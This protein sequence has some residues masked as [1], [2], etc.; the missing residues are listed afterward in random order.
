MAGAPF[1][2]PTPSQLA[3]AFKW[4]EIRQVT[5]TATVRLFSNAYEVDAS[6]VGRKVELVFDPFDLEVMEVRFRGEPMGLAKPQDIGRHAHPKAKPELPADPDP[7]T[8]TGIDYLALLDQ[9]HTESLAGGINY[10]A[11]S[12][13][14][15]P[16]PEQ[17]ADMPPTSGNTDRQSE[18]EEGATLAEDPS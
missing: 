17:T 8:T 2:T 14:D 18:D 13:F 7:I 11:L 9:T 1:P 6:L 16:T 3:E 12:R 5:K 10:A 15:Q 4:S